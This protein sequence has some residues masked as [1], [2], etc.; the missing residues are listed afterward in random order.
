MP[1]PVSE[2]LEENVAAG[3][4]AGQ[5]DGPPGGVYLRALSTRLI[6][7]CCNWSGLPANDGAVLPLGR[8]KG[9]W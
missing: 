6:V 3:G 7:S 4:G 8:L 9:A 1:I 2:T 5:R